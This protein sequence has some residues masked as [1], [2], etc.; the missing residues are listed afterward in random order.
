MTIP[1]LLHAAKTVAVVGL[2]A[3]PDRPSYGVAKRLQQKGFTI[4]PVNPRLKEWE[5]IPAYPY[6]SAIPDEIQVDI[7][8][9]FRVSEATPD[10]VRDVLKCKAKP[11]AIWLQSGILNEESRRLTESGGIFYIED[12]CIAVEAR[13]LPSVT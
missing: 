10:V 6:V 4:I 1:E 12:D 3:E 13:I 8:D 11:M 2:S 7:V 9:V 5:G